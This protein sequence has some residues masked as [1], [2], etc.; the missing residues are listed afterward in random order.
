MMG[1]RRLWELKP[2]LAQIGEISILS[3]ERGNLTSFFLL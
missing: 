1:I 3:T 2:P